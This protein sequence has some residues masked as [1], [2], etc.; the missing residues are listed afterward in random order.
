MDVTDEDD[1]PFNDKAFEEKCPSLII[2][3]G[4][5]DEQ[6]QVDFS[7]SPF[8]DKSN[9]REYEGKSFKLALL[10]EFRKTLPLSGYNIFPQLMRH[11]QPQYPC[12]VH[13]TK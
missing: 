8:V 4:E 6:L 13:L 3:K 11:Q 5:K 1:D 2:L 9:V 12:K 10:N 7:F